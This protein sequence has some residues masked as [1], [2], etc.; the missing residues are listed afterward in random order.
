[1][2]KHLPFTFASFTASD[3]FPNPDPTVIIIIITSLLNKPL[4][5]RNILRAAFHTQA[6]ASFGARRTPGRIAPHTWNPF[7]SF[8]TTSLRGKIPIS[9]SSSD[10][11]G[12]PRPTGVRTSLYTPHNHRL[13]AVTPP[14]SSSI[15]SPL[16]CSC[17]PTR[18]PL[19]LAFSPRATLPVL[20]LI[21]LPPF[22]HTPACE[23]PPV[24]PYVVGGE[25]EARVYR[26]PEGG[27]IVGWVAKTPAT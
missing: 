10:S 22:R 26:R 18:T 6:T 8:R 3:P 27:V 14:T 5:H 12:S 9:Y 25:L 4:L 2:T 20:D 19:T 13:G 23:T 15:L 16:R 24:A 11:W 21:T 17:C 1:M 7:E